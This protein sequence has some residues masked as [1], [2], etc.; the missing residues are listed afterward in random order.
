[1]PPSPITTHI[2]QSL[3]IIH[4]PP[5]QIILNRQPTQ[6]GRQR[7]DNAIRQTPQRRR[8]VD[9]MLRHE[10]V[11]QI[12]PGWGGGGL[13]AGGSVD[14]V[15]EGWRQAARGAQA[16]GCITGNAVEGGQGF[17]DELAL[18][19]IDAQEEDLGQRY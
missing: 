6:T 16:G 10:A 17:A 18:R 7:N 5:P 2:P 12:V 13:S 3:N 8:R 11:Q 1:M 4:Q 14:E 19:E 15:G 9:V